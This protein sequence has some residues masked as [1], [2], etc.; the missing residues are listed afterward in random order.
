MFDCFGPLKRAYRCLVKQKMR[1]GYNHIDKFDFLKAYPAAH[2]EAFT[3]LNIQNCFTAAGI[4]PL[5]PERVLQKLNIHILTP[6]PP[7]KPCINQLILACYTSY[8]RQLHKQA[9]SVKKLLK[10]TL[11][12][13]L[14]AFKSSYTAAYQGLRDGR[15]QCSPTGKG[16]S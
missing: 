8:T 6:N 10:T 15:A 3:P 4:Y 7:S 5:K 9:S 1:L 11:S 12:K 16:E 2:L 13:P 14:D